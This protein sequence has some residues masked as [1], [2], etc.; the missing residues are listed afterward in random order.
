MNSIHVL[1]H[2]NTPWRTKFW[3]FL[4]DK[5]ERS[6]LTDPMRLESRNP[7]NRFYCWKLECNRCEWEEIDSFVLWKQITRKVFECFF[8]NFALVDEASNGQNHVQFTMDTSSTHRNLYYHSSISKLLE[9][10]NEKRKKPCYCIETKWMP[11]A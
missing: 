2:L 1:S 3:T 10:L 7:L 9:F 6:H 11:Q 5:C 8:S 4:M